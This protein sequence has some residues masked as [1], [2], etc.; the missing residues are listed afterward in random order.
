M[1]MKR[2]LRSLPMLL[3][4]I[5]FSSS[6]VLFLEGVALA[7]QSQMTIKIG[8]TVAQSAPGS[9]IQGQEVTRGLEIAKDII[10]GKGGVL[11]RPIQLLYQ[12]TEGLPDAA[13]AAIQRLITSDDVV[14][15]TGEHHSSCA[16][17]EI[18]VAHRY[19]VPYINTNSWADAIREK[20]YPEVV[21]P[22]PDNVRVAEAIATFIKE[23]HYKSVVGFA[24]NTDY[25]IGLA[26]ATGE[27]IKELAPGVKYHYEVLDRQSRDFSSVI[28][29][30]RSKPP[31]L[32]ATFINPP[33]GYL[34][35]KQLYEYGVAPSPKTLVIDGASTSAFPDFWNNVGDAAVGLIAV[36]FYHPEMVL[37]NF[38]TQVKQEYQKRY[39]TAPNR[40]PFQAADSLLLIAKAID[41]AGTTT[42]AAVLKA[43]QN[44]TIEGTRGKITLDHTKGIYYQQWRGVPYVIYQ[45][46]KKNQT[47]ADATLLARPKTTTDPSKVFHPVK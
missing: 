29:P 26:K 17:A 22:S 12:D 7:A 37:S 28:F 42:H 31:D 30:L 9:L 43:L 45:F 19:G 18:E 15:V 33:A 40:L 6:L 3:S 4:L 8:V 5:L 44:I 10:N 36:D 39:G 27:M 32:I 11:K 46:T 14:A 21:N 25:G 38:G 41:Q 47:P 1:N 20:G 13:R 34:L 23:T 35:F 24:E 16:L 2:I